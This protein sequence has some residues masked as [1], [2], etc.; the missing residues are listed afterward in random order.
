VRPARPGTR[1]STIQLWPEHFDA[2]TT[3]TDARGTS[4]NLGF[5][6]GDSFVDEPYLYV[7][8]GGPERPGDPAFWNAPFGAV[9]TRARVLAAGDAG[10]DTDTDTDCFAFIAEGLGHLGVTLRRRSK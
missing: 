2:A 6:A 9:R 7:G 3:V 4:V 1:A 10:A 8:P 5:S